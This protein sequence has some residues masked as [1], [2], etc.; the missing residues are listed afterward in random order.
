MRSASLILS[1]FASLA[2]CDTARDAGAAIGDPTVGQIVIT[3][4]A[5]GSCHTIRE[6]SWQMGWSVRRLPV[7]PRAG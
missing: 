1:I 6:S 4:Q 2:G 5:C 7:L 3:R